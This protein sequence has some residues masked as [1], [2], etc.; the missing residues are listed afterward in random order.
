MQNEGY[1]FTPCGQL[2]VDEFIRYRERIELLQPIA[3]ELRLLGLN[4]LPDYLLE[5]AKCKR[6]VEEVLSM[7]EF[8]K[9]TNRDEM[10]K[11]Q[12]LFFI[13]LCCKTSMTLPAI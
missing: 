7:R 3:P 8:L 6:L 2:T 11:L 13:L 9:V 4:Y 1:S 5:W 10:E 12:G